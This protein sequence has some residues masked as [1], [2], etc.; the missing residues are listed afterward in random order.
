VMRG[1]VAQHVPSA[2]IIALLRRERHPVR[3]EDQVTHRQN[4]TGL[5]T[6]RSARSAKREI[7]A[8]ISLRL[9]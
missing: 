4:V 8:R 6:V 2:I 7:I 9:R 1:E 5:V 3:K